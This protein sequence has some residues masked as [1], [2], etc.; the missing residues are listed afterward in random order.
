MDKYKEISGMF[1]NPY[2]YGDVAFD[3]PSFIVGTT[4]QHT[5]YFYD[6]FDAFHFGAWDTNA[7]ERIFNFDQTIKDL[8]SKLST[9]AKMVSDLLKA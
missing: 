8:E 1:L 9:Y 3:S 5:S 6:A 2:P 4:H 7:V